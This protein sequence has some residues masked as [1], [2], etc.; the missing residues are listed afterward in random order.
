MSAAC[1]RAHIFHILNLIYIKIKLI[2]LPAF[3][4]LSKK[5]ACRFFFRLKEE[6]ICWVLSVVWFDK[7]FLLFVIKLKLRLPHSQGTN[8]IK[9]VSNQFSETVHNYTQTI[10]VLLKNCAQLCIGKLSGCCLKTVHNYTQTIWV[11]LKN[12]AQLYANYLGTA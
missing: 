10:W 11:L 8:F 4:V 3:Q 12:C 7:F 9:R 5:R 2:Y 1:N 6:R